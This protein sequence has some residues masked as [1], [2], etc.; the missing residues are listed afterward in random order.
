MNTASSS[1]LELGGQ[2]QAGPGRGRGPG[3]GGAWEVGVV[4]TEGGRGWGQGVEPTQAG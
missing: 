3:K 4:V 1:D 2:A